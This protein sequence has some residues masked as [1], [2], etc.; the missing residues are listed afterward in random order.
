MRIWPE[1]A[2]SLS[3]HCI[4]VSSYRSPLSK[5]H[6]LIAHCTPI[7]LSAGIICTAGGIVVQDRAAIISDIDNPV[8]IGRILLN[9]VVFICSDTNETVV[10]SRVLHDDITVLRANAITTVA[11]GDIVLDDA[12]VVHFDATIDIIKRAHLFDLARV[13]VTKRE[14]YE[15]VGDGPVDDDNPHPLSA[16]VRNTVP[17]A[18]ALDP[19]TIE[20]DGHMI[21]GDHQAITHCV[22]VANE[23]VGTGFVDGF[24]PINGPAE[25]SRL[26]W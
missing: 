21:G 23:P 1:P 13:G 2:S 22:Q 5:A 14:P 19:V 24:A 4:A 11:V 3:P 16:N 8:A 20:V 12:A 25:K 7:R 10:R 6:C 17:G 26:A 15:A 9:C 18:V